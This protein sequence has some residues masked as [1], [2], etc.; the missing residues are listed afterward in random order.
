MYDWRKDAID[1]FT[2]ALRFKALER[3]SVQFKTIA[4]LYYVESK[5]LIP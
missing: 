3:G 5:G 1:S 2:L 4:E